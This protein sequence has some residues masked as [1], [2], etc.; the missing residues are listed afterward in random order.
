MVTLADEQTSER[1]LDGTLVDLDSYV[2]THF[3]AF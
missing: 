2:L 3:H 1:T